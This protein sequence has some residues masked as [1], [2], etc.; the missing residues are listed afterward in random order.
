MKRAV[1]GVVALCIFGGL[2]LGG[3]QQKKSAPA[4]KSAA[5]KKRKPVLRDL[6]ALVAH[7][8]AQG[9]KISNPKPKFAQM[10]GALEGKGVD[11]EGKW[12]EVYR[13][14]KG[15]D[16]AMSNGQLQFQRLG[17]VTEIKGVFL[18]AYPKQHPAKEQVNKAFQSF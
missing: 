8:Q 16:K 6:D 3:C 7:F 17:A 5:V 10:I 14:A 12:V 13:F 1:L 18:L 11:V 9:L 4:P 2:G 15:K